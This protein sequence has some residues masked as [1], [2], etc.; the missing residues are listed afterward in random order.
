MFVFSRL[1]II[2]KC[3]APIVARDQARQPDN[4]QV[5]QVDYLCNPESKMAGVRR[6]P[7]EDY[8]HRPIGGG[9]ESPA[10]T[11]MIF[12]CRPK[13]WTIEHTT[14]GTVSTVVVRGSG[15][16]RPLY[17]DQGEF[18]IRKAIVHDLVQGYPQEFIKKRG[19]TDNYC[20]YCNKG[21][22]LDYPQTRGRKSQ[23]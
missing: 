17:T 8:N 23:K 5:A 22:H 19:K 10:C 20:L 12:Y 2:T 18:V 15:H 7:R 6:Q 9:L 21:R 13:P 1:Y 16:A 14:R 11:S 4:G 3:P